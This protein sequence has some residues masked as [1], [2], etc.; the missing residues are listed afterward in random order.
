MYERLMSLCKKPHRRKLVFPCMQSG[1]DASALAVLA[2][3]PST[4][5]INQTL[6]DALGPNV[7]LADLQC[8]L[9][10]LFSGGPSQ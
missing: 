1:R 4:V 7:S 8:V 9:C 3:T 10:S 6:L 2:Y 5:L